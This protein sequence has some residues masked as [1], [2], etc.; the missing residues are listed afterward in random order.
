MHNSWDPWQSRLWQQH[1]SLFDPFWSSDFDELLEWHSPFLPSWREC[2]QLDRGQTVRGQ[3]GHQYRTQPEKQ[4]ENVNRPENLC[5]N[6][7]QRDRNTKPRSF[8]NQNSGEAR[9][10]NRRLGDTQHKNM[11]TTNLQQRPVTFAELDVSGYRS[12]ELDIWTE[13]DKVV[14]KG[15]HKC[16]CDDSCLVREF[17]RTYGIPRNLDR[18]SVKAK[19]GRDGKL[20]LQGNVARNPQQI[21]KDQHVEIEYH[22]PKETPRQNVQCHHKKAGIPLKKVKVQRR[23]LQKDSD[24]YNEGSL[25]KTFEGEI[26]DDGVTIEVVE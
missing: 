12:N 22:G 25:D 5:S 19:Y 23:D 20:V 8:T 9:H 21:A 2:N 13:G 18:K 6:D 24:T 1:S 15:H 17:Q 7:N 10:Q 4:P 16:D 11:P 26:G 3:C 14:V